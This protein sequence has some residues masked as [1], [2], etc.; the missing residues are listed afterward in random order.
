MRPRHVILA[1]LGLSIALALYW[2]SRGNRPA[3]EESVTVASPQAAPQ[4]ELA[5]V[6]AAASALPPFHASLAEAQPLPR[7][8]PA[9]RFGNSIVA[10]AYRVAERIPGVL[11][12]QP[13]YCSCEKFGHG[14]L[15]DCY[16]SDHG[17]G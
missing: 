7:T 17:A 1:V 12:Q 13:C 5:P 15:L 6:P 16:A 9:S 4:T 14:S 3:R 11:A 10:R 8:L 2:A